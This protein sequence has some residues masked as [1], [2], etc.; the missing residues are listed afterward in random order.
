MSTLVSLS[1]LKEASL[2][3]FCAM[4]ASATARI[5]DLDSIACGR[6]PQPGLFRLRNYAAPR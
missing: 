3:Q 4:W 6:T 1:I 2:S 5:Y